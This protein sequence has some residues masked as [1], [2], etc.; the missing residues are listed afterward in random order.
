MEIHDIN[1]SNAIEIPHKMVGMANFI[2]KYILLKFWKIEEIVF[3][4]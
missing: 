3:S 4:F 1:V 2:Y